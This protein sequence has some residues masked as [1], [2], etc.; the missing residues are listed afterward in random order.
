MK[1]PEPRW[2]GDPFLQGEYLKK[3]ATN[4]ERKYILER[5]S[6]EEKELLQNLHEAAAG[7]EPLEIFSETPE[8]TETSKESKVALS[9]VLVSSVGLV[10]LITLLLL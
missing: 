7:A 6:E 10:L 8:K 4:H 1:F 9:A 2:R 5:L 3:L